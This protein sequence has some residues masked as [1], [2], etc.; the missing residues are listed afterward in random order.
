MPEGLREKRGVTVHSVPSNMLRDA[1]KR[2][3]T[4][5][6]ILPVN[7]NRGAAIKHR[8]GDWPCNEWGQRGM[9]GG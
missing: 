9:M 2:Q 4:P 1:Q 5:R 8:G 3:K 6:G 7:S